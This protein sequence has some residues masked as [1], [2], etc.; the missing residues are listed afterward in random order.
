M[1][2][3]VELWCSATQCQTYSQIIDTGHCGT[4]VHRLDG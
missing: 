2:P 3:V 4:S 1:Y